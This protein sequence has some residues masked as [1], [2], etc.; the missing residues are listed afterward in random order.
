MKKTGAFVV[1]IKE[2]HISIRFMRMV[3]PH[4]H[5]VVFNGQCK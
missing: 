4:I 5:V 3:F 1:C 2:I